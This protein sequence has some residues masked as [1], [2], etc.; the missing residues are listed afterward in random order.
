MTDASPAR[1]LSRRA[2][3]A[4]GAG[5]SDEAWALWEQALSL[6]PRDTDTAIEFTNALAQAGEARRAVETCARLL[7]AEPDLAVLWLQ[8]GILLCNHLADPEAAI[9]SITRSLGLTPHDTIA[10]RILAQIHFFNFRPALMRRHAALA[11]AGAD[12]KSELFLKTRYLSDYEGGADL[13]RRIL[14]ETP[15]DVEALVALAKCLRMQGRLEESLQLIARA[16]EIPPEHL[17]IVGQHGDL[18]LLLGDFEGG[19]RCVEALA[20]DALV[21]RNFP[22]IAQYLPRRWGGEP[23]AGKRILVAYSAG[24]G[25]NLMMA[26]YARDLKAAGAYVAFACRPELLRLLRGLDGADEVTDT[27]DIPRWGEF[28]YWV[29]DYILPAYL[30]AAQ[31]RIPAYP[32]G[33]VT[34]PTDIAA[35]WDARLGDAGGRLRVGLCWFSGPH[36]FTGLDRFVPAEALAPLAEL[37]GVDW[38]VMQKCGDNPS[39]RAV[40]PENL[41]D[42]SDGWYDFADSAAIMRRLDLLISVDSS[43]LHLA[44]ALGVPAWALIPAA[45]EWRWGLTGEYSPWYPGVR[46][47]RQSRLY[48]WSDVIARVKAELMGLLASRDPPP[49]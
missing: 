9:V 37:A 5:R 40:I 30:G 19:W 6:D 16:A 22:Y 3:E 26:R 41:H 1:E 49:K 27:W 20:S 21:T 13:A 7:E 17:D 43:P 25:D 10:H 35:Q 47:F 28:D 2:Q 48:D 31:G 36:N 34:V 29:F 39:I 46:I 24:I 12:L 32:E 45:P 44:G 11:L 33:Y 38:F 42:L 14:A 8:H 18:R 15:D 23:L 4:L